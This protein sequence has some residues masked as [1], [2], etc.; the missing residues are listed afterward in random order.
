MNCILMSSI[1]SLY[2]AIT[3][4]FNINITK[5]Y[6]YNKLFYSLIC[7]LIVNIIIIDN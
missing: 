2:I 6:Q 5:L 3:I 7:K 4:K 1:L